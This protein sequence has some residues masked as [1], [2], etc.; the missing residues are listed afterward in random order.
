MV[1]FKKIIMDI[2]T[3]QFEKAYAKGT[4]SQQYLCSSSGD[5]LLKIASDYGLDK[6]AYKK[7]AITVGDTVL[8]FYNKTDLP[9]ILVKKVGVSEIVA[10]KMTGDLLDFFT[11][12]TDPNWQP[13]EEIPNGNT[14]SV[15]EEITETEREIQS[16]SAVHSMASDE[17]SPASQSAQAPDTE[18]PAF[19]SMQ[20]DLLRKNNPADSD[21]PKWGSDN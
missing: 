21:S 16:L 15:Q 19:P 13:P 12:L 11:P 7:F 3:E 4:Q 5:Q 10:I 20:A 14:L 18:P 1:V 6:A 17:K 2:T 8:G 9:N